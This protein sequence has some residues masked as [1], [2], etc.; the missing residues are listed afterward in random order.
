VT[1]AF[2]R[3]PRSLSIVLSAPSVEAA[4]GPAASGETGLIARLGTLDPKEIG[5]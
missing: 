3:R 5:A 1:T 2:H 4:A